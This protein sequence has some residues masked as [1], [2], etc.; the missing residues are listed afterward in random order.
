MK[1]KEFTISKPSDSITD[2]PSKGLS[3]ND[4]IVSIKEYYINLLGRD[5]QS[6]NTHYAYEALGLAIRDR[7]MERW[8]KT[9]RTYKQA[10]CKRTFYC[11]WNT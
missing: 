9:H 5:E 10:R 6:K 3:K 4:F 7:I 11:L 2:L 8:K 1:N